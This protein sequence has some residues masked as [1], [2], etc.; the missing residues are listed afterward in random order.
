MYKCLPDNE[1]IACQFKF[2][3]RLI[4]I[5]CRLLEKK[6]IVPTGSDNALKCQRDVNIITQLF[7]TLCRLTMCFISL[8][9]RHFKAIARHIEISFISLE[10][11]I[12]INVSSF[13]SL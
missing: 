2:L 5:L 9:R 1:I 4:V 12:I 11:G 6:V 13:Y 8:F 10:V 3:S 7:N